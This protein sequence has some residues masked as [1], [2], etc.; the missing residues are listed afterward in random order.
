MGSGYR[1]TGDGRVK[2]QGDREQTAHLQTVLLHLPVRTQIRTAQPG[3]IRGTWLGTIAAAH[4]LS[5]SP[6]A[7][8]TC[9]CIFE[10]NVL[11][12]K[13]IGFVVC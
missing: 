9:Q 12:E 13:E 1:S 5:S 4:G 7:G 3:S 10:S 11:G 6:A 2:L 8:L